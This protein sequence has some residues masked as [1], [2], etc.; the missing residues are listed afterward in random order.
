V[1][2]HL[3]IYT[4]AKAIDEQS[5]ATRE[6]SESVRMIFDEADKVARGEDETAN[7]SEVMSQ[8]S[9]NLMSLANQFKVSCSM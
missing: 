7:L 9:E 3:Y 4:F 2:T 1:F 8:T 6:I 5:L